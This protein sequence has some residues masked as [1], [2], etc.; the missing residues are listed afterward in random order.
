MNLSLGTMLRLIKPVLF[1]T[2]VAVLRL[3]AS[4]KQEQQ[5]LAAL[6][7]VDKLEGRIAAT[8]GDGEVV[9]IDLATFK[10]TLLGA[11]PGGVWPGLYQCLSLRSIKVIPSSP[12]R[13]SR[14]QVGA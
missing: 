2:W 12:E 1:I 5:E 11:Y 6:F 4:P 9:V 3:H 14:H 7:D 13:G 8:R 10:T